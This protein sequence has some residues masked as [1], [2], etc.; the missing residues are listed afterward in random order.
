MRS[1]FVAAT[2]C[3]SLAAIA[4]CAA[5]DST[6]SPDVVEPGTNLPDASP[7]DAPDPDVVDADVPDTRLPDCGSA[8]WCIT[9]F[10]HADLIFYDIAPLED[11]AFAIAQSRTEGVKVLEWTSSTNA[12]RYIDDQTQNGANVGTFA[13]GIYAPSANEVYFT[14][15]P[16]YVYHGTRPVPPATEWVWTRQA[17]PD[18][19]VGHPSND[20]HGYPIYNLGREPRAALGVWGTSADNVYAY[21]S[22]SIFERA[23]DG[24][25]STVYVAD[26]L[27]ASTEH[28]FFLSASGTGPDDVWFSGARDRTSW[29]CPL[30]VRKTAEGWRR[31]ADGVVSNNTLTPCAPRANTTWLTKAAGG[32]WLREITAVSPTEYVAL[33]DVMNRAALVS[34]DLTRFR[35]TDDGYTVEQTPVPYRVTQVTPSLIN[36]LWRAPDGDN[37]FAA[38]G[39]VLHGTNDGAH[40]VSTLSRDGAPINVP[41]FKIRGTSNQ[42]LWAIGARHAFHKT[43]P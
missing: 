30:A 42:N 11:V 34:I 12:W 36:S 28:I 5:A 23:P 26:D 24:T 4:A 32:G 40:V 39:L 9:P 2:A 6:T 37:W 16:S 20:D 19:V 17:L 14:V 21:Y 13:G 33:H 3:A 35:V 29:S 7:H 22:N 38:W 43:T 31:V 8:G 10:P 41:I 15:G 18:N 1:K 27:D 25:W